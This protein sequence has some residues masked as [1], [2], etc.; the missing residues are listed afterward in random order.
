MVSPTTR[1]SWDWFWVGGLSVGFACSPRVHMGFRLIGDSKLCVN[2][3][4]RGG[5]CEAL[6]GLCSS[7]Y[8]LC[9]WC[10]R[11]FQ[12]S[13]RRLRR[14]Q[15]LVIMAP[16]SYCTSSFARCSAFADS[17]VPHCGTGPVPCGNGT[18]ESETTLAF[19]KVFVPAIV[20]KRQLMAWR[21]HVASSCLLRAERCGHSVVFDECFF[22]LHMI[23]LQ[24]VLLR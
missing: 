16:R 18:V 14:K 3:S 21:P 9:G 11:M 1:G 8:L 4:V 17:L 12:H 5:V 7:L 24:P 10:K 20:S 15:Q 19:C 6:V 13:D 2:V 23:M 22:L